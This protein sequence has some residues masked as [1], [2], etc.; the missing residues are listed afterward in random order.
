MPRESGSN[1]R[2]AACIGAGTAPANELARANFVNSLRSSRIEWFF[3]GLLFMDQTS[4]KL[5]LK[6][7]CRFPPPSRPSKQAL[8]ATAETCRTDQ[9]TLSAGF[10]CL[11]L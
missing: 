9:E 6:F 7:K 1:G 10:S 2:F 8:P 5:E 3:G 4:R 11:V